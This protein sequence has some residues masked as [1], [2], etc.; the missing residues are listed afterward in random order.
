LNIGYLKSLSGDDSIFVRDLFEKGKS[1]KEIQPMFKLVFICNK[2][3][4]IKNADEATFNRIRVLPFES[5]FVRRGE[6][7]PETFE[8]QLRQKKFPRDDNFKKKIPELLEPFCYMLLEHRKALGTNTRYVPD[9]VKA[10]TLVYQKQN[11]R[12]RQFVEERIKEDKES[13]LHID[14]L[15]NEFKTWYR[16]SFSGQVPDKNEI[17]EHFIKK[18][19]DLDN[20]YRWKGFRIKGMNDINSDEIAHIDYFSESKTK[21]EETTP[22]DDGYESEF[23]IYDEDEEVIQQPHHNGVVINNGTKPIM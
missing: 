20:T 14:E 7:V 12:L 22:N 5:K 3:P 2:N 1:T 10:A 11:D 21:T 13:Y 18:W 6:S 9:K 17:K 8:E 23:I 15:Y 19:G 4:R 16:D